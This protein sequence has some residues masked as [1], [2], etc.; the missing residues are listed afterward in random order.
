MARTQISGLQMVNLM[1]M[2]GILKWG[3]CGCGVCGGG[4]F[5]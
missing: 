1:Q 5:L 4:I 3:R 2:E